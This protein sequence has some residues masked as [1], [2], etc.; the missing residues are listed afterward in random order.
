[1][2]TPPQVGFN[3]FPFTGIVRGWMGQEEEREGRKRTR[4]RRGG[5]AVWANNIK[6]K[7]LER[8]G[9]GEEATD[10]TAPRKSRGGNA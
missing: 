9:R 4:G 7:E 6:P 10:A 3:S 8:R 5:V 1:M 2:L